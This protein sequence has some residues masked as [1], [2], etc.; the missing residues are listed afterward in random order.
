MAGTSDYHS[1][2]QEEFMKKTRILFWVTFCI[3]LLMFSSPSQAVTLSYDFS[4]G[5]GSDFTFENLT[6][7]FTLD[8][9]GGELRLSKAAD[10]EP[11]YFRPAR[12]RA[13]YLLQ[14]DFEVRVGYRINISLNDGDQQQL[15]LGF[16]DGTGLANVRSNESWL[17]GNNYH[18]WVKDHEEPTGGISTSDVSGTLV[19]K[20]SGNT[21]SAYFRSPGANADTF[22]TSKTVSV[23]LIAFT[24]SLQSQPNSHGALDASFDNLYV[25]ADGIVVPITPSHS[26]PAI[27]SLL[28]GD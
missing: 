15:N 9:S 10:S 5:M 7:L 8:D 11:N 13:N 20:R 28:L 14:G 18:V 4:S 16:L 26:L 21:I 25:R 24:M 17:G 27:L 1:S 6:G 3:C 23:P 2:A 12:I 22:L 19:Y